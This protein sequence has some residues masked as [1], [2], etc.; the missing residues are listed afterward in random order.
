MS[1][2]FST[3][4]SDLAGKGFHE[5]QGIVKG[6]EASERI[7]LQ[8]IFDDSKPVPPSHSKE[9]MEL[10]QSLHKK[11]VT[12]EEACCFSWLI[13][14]FRGPWFKALRVAL[15]E[16]MGSFDLATL[17]T[18]QL[19]PPSKLEASASDD[20]KSIRPPSPPIAIDTKKQQGIQL[21][22]TRGIEL[23]EISLGSKEEEIA[24]S[25]DALKKKIDLLEIAISLNVKNVSQAEPN[26][27]LKEVETQIR[28]L[29]QDIKSLKEHLANKREQPAADVEE[30]DDL[31]KKMDEMEKVLIKLESLLGTLKTKIRDREAYTG[32][33]AKYHANNAEVPFH[34]KDQESYDN[35][36]ANIKAELARNAEAV[37]ALID[38]I[39]REISHLQKLFPKSELQ[40]QLELEDR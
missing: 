5:V 28:R 18:A 35:F 7:L 2:C 8:R 30:I 9:E 13:N 23:P 10:L 31:S 11:I 39:Q 33:V 36:I 17:V 37:P 26:K 16:F 12:N 27:A 29:K 15:G 24:D 25:I 4:K 6:L 1:V 38:D 20:Q 3:I 34:I 14:F 21:S 19:S 22:Q 40:F 32:S